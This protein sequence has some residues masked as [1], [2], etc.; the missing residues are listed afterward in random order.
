MS[1]AFARLSEAHQEEVQKYLHFMRAK[2]DIT[3]GELQ[4]D[5]E[6]ANNDRL[7]E[8]MYS[9]EDVQGILRSLQTVVK[10]NVRQEMGSLINMTSLLIK[11]LL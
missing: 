3:L 4:G 8:D 7:Y 5:F 9:L 6:D 11:Q 10:A 2:R 1:R